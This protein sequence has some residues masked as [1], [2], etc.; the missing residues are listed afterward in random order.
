MRILDR[1]NKKYPNNYEWGKEKYWEEQLSKIWKRKGIKTK[2]F[3][4]EKVEIGDASFP[5]VIIQLEN[6]LR[7][8]D[9]ENC[10]PWAAEENDKILSDIEF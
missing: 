4:I 2:P 1:Y 7:L 9:E 3:G 5:I 6:G 8:Y 10:P